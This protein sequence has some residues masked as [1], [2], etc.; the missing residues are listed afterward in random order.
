VR[1]SGGGRPNTACQRSRSAP[2][3][4]DRTRAISAAM[5]RIDNPCSMVRPSPQLGARVRLAGHPIDALAVRLFGLQ[6]QGELLRSPASWPQWSH[7]A[8]GSAEPAPQPAWTWH[9]YWGGQSALPIS[10]A[11]GPTAALRLSD[12]TAVSSFCIRLRRRSGRTNILTPH[13]AMRRRDPK[14]PLPPRVHDA[15]RVPVSRKNSTASV[16]TAPASGRP[17]T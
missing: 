8:A 2:P 9:V 3:D 7:H 17:S 13:A 5:A 6:G 11:I 4:S 12:Q 16:T 14:P 1:C 15:P 10:P